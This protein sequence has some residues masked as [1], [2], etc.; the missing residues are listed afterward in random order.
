MFVLC[1]AESENVSVFENNVK[2][3]PDMF[4]TGIERYSDKVY[5]VV[6]VKKALARGSKIVIKTI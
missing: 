4:L 1:G 6:T 3:N 5:T 2:L